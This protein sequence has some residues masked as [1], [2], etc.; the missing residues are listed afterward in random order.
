VAEHANDQLPWRAG[1]SA[2]LLG[3][4]RRVFA[5][6]DSTGSSAESGFAIAGR[7]R[8]HKRR[9]RSVAAAKTR[10]RAR[11]QRPSAQARRR[12]SRPRLS[13]TSRPRIHAKPN[14]APVWTARWEATPPATADRR[15]D[16]LRLG[17]DLACGYVVRARPQVL[18]LA[19]KRRSWWMTSV[20]GVVIVSGETRIET[21]SRR[22]GLRVGWSSRLALRPTIPA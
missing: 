9:R 20:I 5:R 18:H 10:K 13:G 6:V 11:R 19:P 3:L 7:Y 21:R 12:L 17:F 8:W 2:A 4:D 15:S 1:T 14:A 22:P 16:T